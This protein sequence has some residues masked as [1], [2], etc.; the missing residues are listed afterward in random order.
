[1]TVVAKFTCIAKTQRK[2]WSGTPP[3]LYEYEFQA[4]T[5]GSEENK[6][7]FG[8]TPG[9]NLKLQAV[10]EDLFD[11]GKDYYLTFNVAEPVAAN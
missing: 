9:G 4:V 5:S 8:S 1:M 3:Y 11:P 2:G 10:R 7:F 6:S